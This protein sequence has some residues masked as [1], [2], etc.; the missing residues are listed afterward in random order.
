M[1]YKIITV[2]N[3]YVSEKSA[4]TFQAG[5]LSRLLTEAQVSA[6]NQ[7][8]LSV[9]MSDA[10][11]GKTAAE[12]IAWV[13]QFDQVYRLPTLREAIRIMEFA[14]NINLFSDRFIR[15]QDAT[16]TNRYIVVGI[17]DGKIVVDDYL[18]SAVAPKI[19]AIFILQE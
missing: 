10:T 17:V 19:G 13:R 8:D 2:P 3:R 4:V 9:I 12:Q 7:R 18:E 14:L 16:D 15:C 11:L 5:A 6:T 1:D